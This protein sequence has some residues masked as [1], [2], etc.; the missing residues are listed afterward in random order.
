[1]IKKYILFLIAYLPVLFIQSDEF[2]N[3]EDPKVTSWDVFGYYSYL[4]Q[5]FVNDDPGNQ[6]L[7]KLDADCRKYNFSPYL[8]HFHK[9]KKNYFLSQYPA[10][11]A[12]LFTPA[13]ICGNIVA[14]IT[15]HEKDGYSPPYQWSMLIWY[16]IYTFLGLFFLFKVLT[17]LFSI[18][19]AFATFLILI[20]GTNFYV[21][22]LDG[23]GMPHLYLF[24]LYS[25]LI[26]QVIKW[27]ES[28]SRKNTFIIGSIMGLMT[29]CRL[30]ELIGILIPLLWNVRDFSGFKNKLI[31]LFHRK[32]MLWLWFLM[33]FLI[34]VL[35]QLVYW[36]IYSGTYFY[37]SYRNAGE[38]FEFLIPHTFDFLF[39]FRKGWF[40]YT[41]VMILAMAGIVMMFL[42]K[43]K[44]GW[45]LFSF[46]VINIYVLSCWSNWWYASSFGSR[47]V[48]QTYPV[49]IL[50]LA[51]SLNYLMSKKMVLRI[52]AAIFISFCI[53]LNLFQS[54]QLRHD[55]IS[56]YRMTKDYYFA[57]FLKTS[58]PEGAEKMLM[59]NRN[60]IDIRT[61]SDSSLYELSKEFKLG[62]QNAPISMRSCFLN[63]EIP[64]NFVL[65]GE[66]E[67][68]PA[69]Y[70]QFSD[71]TESDHFKLTIS[72]EFRCSDSLSRVMPTF[73]HSFINSRD[74]AYFWKGND[75]EKME[76]PEGEWKS[77]RENY[78]SP[79][80]RTRKDNFSF[81]FWIRGEGNIEIRNF[82]LKF[83]N[84]TQ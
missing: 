9:T 38:G 57:I 22:T 82:R 52:T 66:R 3:K 12:V 63:D 58:I 14:G 44:N 24:M 27:H 64:G 23:P 10:G 7:M 35:P 37:Y 42:K 31:V 55:I 76:W 56:N 17:H 74:E 65:N 2:I 6:D 29:I 81:Y 59:V 20:Y 19:I 83:Y 33:G 40:I 25:A 41:P 45:I 77:Y 54:W 8:Y 62:R 1:M 47:T 75:L 13:F 16:V 72:F 4:P 43:E 67:N 30:T 46:T 71:L 34:F 80:V 49:Y 60:P 21:Y 84:R 26:W 68:Y 79:E 28:P 51:Y 11:M 5:T 50:G 39:S 70:F 15:G 73:I 48:I 53:F 36:K 78:I 69:K 32:K 61:F 18:P